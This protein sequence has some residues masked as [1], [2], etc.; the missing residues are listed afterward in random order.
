MFSYFYAFVNNL[1]PNKDFE[2]WVYSSLDLLSQKLF[3]DSEL[4]TE[5]LKCDYC[6]D[7][8]VEHLKFLLRNRY[9]LAS[10]NY[11]QFIDSSDEKLIKIMNDY[12]YV[13]SKIIFDCTGIDTPYKLHKKI[14]VVF[15]FS[16][17]YGKNWHAFED[18]IDISEVRVIKIINIG[19]MR[20]AIPH[21]TECFL[22]IIK[23]NMPKNCKLIF[24]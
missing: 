8:D 11:A 18:F 5:I 14:Q 9:D 16:E 2:N 24:E 17:Y 3:N 7:N 15:K 4:Y 10:S 19:K 13:G 21:D 12:L 22:K 20:E 23:R 1:I 6:F